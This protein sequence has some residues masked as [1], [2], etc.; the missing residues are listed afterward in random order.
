MKQLMQRSWLSKRLS[1]NIGRND[2]FFRSL[3]GVG[4][5]MA[6]WLLQIPEIFWPG[7]YFIVTATFKFCPNYA[8]FNFNTLGD[9]E[10]KTTI[11]WEV[12]LDLLPNRGKTPFELDQTNAEISNNATWTSRVPLPTDSKVVRPDSAE[13][14]SASSLDEPDIQSKKATKFIPNIDYYLPPD[15]TKALIKDIE[16]NALDEMLV[17]RF[18]ENFFGCKTSIEPA[19]HLNI[20]VCQFPH[21]TIR[22]EF[23]RLKAGLLDRLHESAH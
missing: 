13:L 5:V 19:A 23:S 7:I 20:Y 8:I 1:N 4:M 18:Y 9:E 12:F 21:K 2:R 15:L 6:G 3:F 14:K 16:K 10:P 11:P 22:L 17:V